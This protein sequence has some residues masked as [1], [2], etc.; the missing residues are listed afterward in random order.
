MVPGAPVMD[1][2]RPVFAVQAIHYATRAGRVWYTLECSHGERSWL[3]E[4]R[5]SHVRSIYEDLQKPRLLGEHLYGQLFNTIHGVAQ[6]P[7][8]RTPF[9]SLE[10]EM[11]VLNRWLAVLS[12]AV[13]NGRIPANPV[14]SYFRDE[15]ANTLRIVPRTRRDDLCQP[16]KDKR[17]IR[18]IAVRHGEADHNAHALGSAVGAVSCRDSELTHKGERQAL[19]LGRVLR[20][21]AATFDLVVV[22]PL[23]RALTTC[24]YLFDTGAM[25][26]SMV[27]PLAAEHRFFGQRDSRGTPVSELRDRF[28]L[29]RFYP[30][31]SPL[32]FPCGLREHWWRWDLAVA[33]NSGPTDKP[34]R[35]HDHDH[36][37]DHEHEHEH[38][39]GHDHGG[40]GHDH[41]G[42]WQIGAS[43]AFGFASMLVVDKLSGGYG[44]SHGPTTAPSAAS[45]PEGVTVHRGDK[46]GTSA[47]LG[48][49]VH[50]AVDGVALGASTSAGSDSS[51]LVFFAI[52]LHKAPAAFGLSTY[53]MQHGVNLRGVKSQLLIFSLAAPVGAFLTFYAMRIGAVAYQQQTIAL[54][55]LFSGGTF[56]FVATA[57]ILPEIMHTSSGKLTWTEVLVVTCGV[58]M[59]LFINLEHGH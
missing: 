4:R 17:Y 25:P 27:Q 53:L 59:P 40:H 15:V 8:S 38:E 35:D 23:V 5:L 46:G 21:R 51:W 31:H 52:M 54:I 18:I 55:M 43:L 47:M 56:L 41:A 7:S 2:V 13:T 57:H 45:L 48:L 9:T 1:S 6:F 39:S 58:V 3:C 29:F 11:E 37:H 20:E 19:E 30:D 32:D 36:E 44:H 50:A 24:A 14:V 12:R 33:D 16:P 28:P 42:H 22:S 34:N 49:I 26:P 10:K